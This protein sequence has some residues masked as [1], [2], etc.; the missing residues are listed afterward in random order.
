MWLTRW[1]RLTFADSFPLNTSRYP[2]NNSTYNHKWTQNS[3]KCKT[4][5]GITALSSLS[6]HFSQIPNW[7][8]ARLALEAIKA[9]DKTNQQKYLLFS[10][11]GPGKRQPTTDLNGRATPQPHPGPVGSISYSHRS[12]AKHRDVSFAPD[13]SPV[14]D[15]IRCSSRNGI[16]THL[17][18]HIWDI[19]ARSTPAAETADLPAAPHLYASRLDL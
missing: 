3:E 7:A 11:K 14:T 18:S 9:R 12:E 1:P 19:A 2:V 17:L 5:D 4:N 10:V 13:L 8:P 15:R 6:F 16:G